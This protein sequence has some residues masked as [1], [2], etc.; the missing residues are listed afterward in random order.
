MSIIRIPRKLATRVAAGDESGV[1]VARTASKAR[2]NVDDGGEWHKEYR[3]RR[4]DFAGRERMLA[5]NAVGPFTN[6]GDFVIES[7]RVDTL[8]GVPVPSDADYLEWRFWGSGASLV[9][10][11]DEM[12]GDSSF[13][14]AESLVPEH[15]LLVRRLRAVG[16]AASRLSLAKS[17][18]D[19]T[20]TAV[21]EF[22]DDENRKYRDKIAG[23]DAAAV[24]KITD[25]VK[26]KVMP[27]LEELRAAAAAADAEYQSAKAA[28]EA[29]SKYTP[30][31]ED[32]P[33]LAGKFS[34]LAV[35]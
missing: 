19:A 7:R 12:L 31:L 17:A 10:V 28:G 33:E 5:S 18:R 32:F 16:D 29:V 4:L 20:F 35:S 25:R 11:I 21:E 27:V 6:L 14:I 34:P 22:K 23:K 1:T 24:K 30:A 3:V 15:A 26:A 13:R 9:E 2:L 8:D